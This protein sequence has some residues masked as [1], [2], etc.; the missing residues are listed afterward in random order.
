MA[1]LVFL[2]RAGF[3]ERRIS[4]RAQIGEIPAICLGDHLI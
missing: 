4:L 2:S 3:S 1:F